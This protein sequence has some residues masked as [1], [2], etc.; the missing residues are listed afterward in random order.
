[1]A[2]DC[3]LKL[4][5]LAG[6]TSDEAHKDWIEINSFQVGTNVHVTTASA[7]ART[8]GRCSWSEAVCTK[9]CDKATPK[10]MLAAC[11]GDHFKEATVVICR[12]TGDKQKY[13][14]YKMEDALISS[15]STSVHD[16]SE[17]LPMESFSI[18]FGKITFTYT[19]TDHKT[20][21]PAGDVFSFWDQITN[22]G[23]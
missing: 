18:N 12:A 21:K 16:G 3:F 9:T 13:M 20:G 14:E 23:G 7:G 8:S 11:K 22:K 6:E 2:F 5:G 17:S 10:L 19:M 15:F 1:M 4:T